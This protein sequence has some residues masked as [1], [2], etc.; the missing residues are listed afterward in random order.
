MTLALLLLG[1]II[2]WLLPERY[3]FWAWMVVIIAVVVPWRAPQNHAHWIRVR[4]IPF[5]SPPVLLRDIAGNI[6]LY[7]P[8]G[9]FY[10][11]RKDRGAVLRAGVLWALLLSAGTECSQLFSHGRFPSVQDVLMNVLGAAVGIVAHEF[12]RPRVSL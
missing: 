8:Y 11:S 6:M 9:F 10:G 3:R 12:V 1:L 2:V 7:V 4:W 5:V